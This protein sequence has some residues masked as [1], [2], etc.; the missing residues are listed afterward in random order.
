[1]GLGIGSWK[2]AGNFVDIGASRRRRDLD[3][4][5]S[6]SSLWRVLTIGSASALG[7]LSKFVPLGSKSKKHNEFK[8]CNIECN[9]LQNM[10]WWNLIHLLYAT[11]IGCNTGSTG[12]E[13]W[14]V[15]WLCDEVI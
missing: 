3:I 11:S 5:T 10:K 8:Q 15:S 13:T 12:Y 1:M 14:I 4:E 6:G 2:G 9:V 7:R